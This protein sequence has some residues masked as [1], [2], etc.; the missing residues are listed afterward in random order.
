MIKH[1]VMWNLKDRAAGGDKAANIAIMKERLEGLMG[2]IE[3]LRFLQVGPGV[4]DNGW[5]VCLYSE[6]DD[7][8]AL[9]FYRN[10][11]LHLDVQKFVHEVICERASC[12]FESE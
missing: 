12:D 10:H 2:K 3:G 9:K 8:E 7:L 4:T 6:F 11:P 1:L 5:D